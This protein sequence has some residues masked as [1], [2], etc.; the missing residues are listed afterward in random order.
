MYSK[1]SFRG[2]KGVGPRELDQIGS[3]SRMPGSSSVSVRASGAGAFTFKLAWL[4]CGGTVEDAE[5][6]DDDMIAVD[7]V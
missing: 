2:G 3:T 5:G 4:M 7:V 1:D 6:A